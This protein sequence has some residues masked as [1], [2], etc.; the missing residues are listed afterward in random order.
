MGPGPS[1]VPARVLRA[2]ASPLLGHLDP[3][4][5]AVLERIRDR[6]RRIFGT[7]NE[8]TLAL[9]GTGTAAMEAS[10][11]NLLEPGAT[12]V[13]GVCGYFGA[14]MADIAGRLGARVLRVE[15]AWGEIVPEEAM[16]DAVRKARPRVVGLVHAETSTGVLQP[17]SAIATVARETG[18]LVVLDCVTSLGGCAVEVDGWGVDVAYGA[19]QKCLGAPPGLAPITASERA[20]ETMKRRRSPVPG[21]Y[22]DLEELA[23]Y[24][25]AEHSYHHTAPAHL[26]FALD[27]ALESVLE[28]GIEARIE[29]HLRHHGALVAGLSAMGLG[30]LS[31]P[32]HRLP[33]LHPV[34]VPD[35]VS[36]EDIRRELLSEH[37]IEIGAGLGPWRGRVWRVGLMGGSADANHVLLF[38]GALER[39]LRSRGVELPASG[40]EAA[41]RWYAARS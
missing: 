28:E 24:W 19:S 34:R 9:S 1:D 32:A 11:S 35:G 38:L 37:G 21:F 14:R 23:R 25:G 39:A 7:R 6:L 4:F 40:V 20:V 41:S 36:E 30:L 17:V 13:V 12:V 10:L 26:Y 31:N 27:E 3:E 16:A 15:A 33:V 8:R 29:R 5:L 2:M 18:A 22:L